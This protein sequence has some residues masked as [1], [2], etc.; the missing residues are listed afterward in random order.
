MLSWLEIAIGLA[1]W[2]AVLWDGFA[3]II[4]PRTVTPMRRISG[5]FYKWSWRLWSAIGRRIWDKD[6]GLSFLAVYG[7]V[8]VMLLLVLWGGL[9]M[10][11][12]AIIYHGLGDRF[13][14]D[15]GS[16]GF[17]ALLYMS[18]STFF[19]LGLGDITSLD[20][21]ARFFMILETG[22]GYLFLGLMITYMP[23]L[24]QA[25]AAREVGNL[26]ILSRAGHPPNGIKLFGR[27]SGSENS[28]ILRGIL[29]EAERWM[30]ETL[31]SHLSHPVLAF[32]RAHHRGQSWLVSLTTI[33]DTASLLI[34]IGDG[35]IAAQARITYRMGIRMIKDLTEALTLKVDRNCRTRLIESDLAHLNAALEG[36][37]DTLT[38]RPGS[39]NQI[40]RLVTRYDAHLLA[41]SKTLV[42]PLPPWFSTSEERDAPDTFEVP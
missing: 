2:G 33:L 4:L 30:A 31:Q 34:V 27:Y 3:T 40:L 12:F 21:L 19:T 35:A 41:L 20:P 42:I 32:Y 23:L 5:R 38:L 22:T 16:I 9:L 11:A 18:G 1:I 13:Q 7:P 10:L 6:W 28:D 8:S 29:R 26:L 15:R 14:A 39:S 36:S 37:C 24:H 17:G 25:Y